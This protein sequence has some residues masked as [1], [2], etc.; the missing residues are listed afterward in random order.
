MN[1]KY[2]TETFVIKGSSKEE[3]DAQ[4]NKLQVDLIK[5]FN[6]DPDAVKECIAFVDSIRQKIFKEK[7]YTGEETIEIGKKLLN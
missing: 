4:L 7:L 3:I 1:E 5:K 2:K 6:N